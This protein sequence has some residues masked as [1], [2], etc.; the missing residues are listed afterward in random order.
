MFVFVG[1]AVMTVLVVMLVAAGAWL[2]I[3]QRREERLLCERSVE[4]RDDSRAMWLWLI[5][6]VAGSSPLAPEARI[7]LN[8]RIPALRCVDNHPEP[9]GSE[10]E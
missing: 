3:D 2:A 9:L 1:S 10:G 8:E 5:D 4:V 7:Q 6:A